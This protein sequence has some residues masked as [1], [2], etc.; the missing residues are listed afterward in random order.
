MANRKSEERNIRSLQKTA[1]GSSYALT[2]P[3]EYI[4]KLGW[5]AKQ[6]LDVKLVGDKIIIADWKK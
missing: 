2:I 6:K 3:R 4:V 5:R 1:G